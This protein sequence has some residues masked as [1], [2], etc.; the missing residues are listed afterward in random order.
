MSDPLLIRCPACG[1][2]NR[3]ARDAIAGGRRPVCG[4]CKAPLPVDATPVEVTDST[5][6][7]VVE[8]S[9]LPVVLDVW[10]PWCA[11][12][13]IIAPVLDELARQMAGRVRFAKLNIDDNPS[14]ASR[15]QVR[16]VPTLLVLKGGREVDRLVGVRPQAEIRQRLERIAA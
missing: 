11:P 8:G 7:S 2:T 15:F 10:A 12:C 3:V 14:T 13:R 1:A 6:A 16:S 9:P 5:F 4:R